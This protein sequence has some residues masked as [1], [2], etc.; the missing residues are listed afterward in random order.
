[1]ASR[2]AMAEA[3]QRADCLTRSGLPYRCKT[4]ACARSYPQY[5]E[6]SGH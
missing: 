4:E 2:E 6:A 1:M 3:A 5:G